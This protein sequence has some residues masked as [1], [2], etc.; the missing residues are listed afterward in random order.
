MLGCMLIL[1]PIWVGDMV[2]AR[3]AIENADVWQNSELDECELLDGLDS[4]GTLSYV[5]VSRSVLSLEM[6]KRR[7]VFA[8]LLSEMGDCY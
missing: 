4:S 2:E 6:S 1:R 8:F 5:S 3:L 7:A